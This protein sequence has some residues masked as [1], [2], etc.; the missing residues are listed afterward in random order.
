MDDKSMGSIPETGSLPA[1]GRLAVSYVPTQKPNS[2]QYSAADALK[3]GTLFPGLNLPFRNHI[4]NRAI[5][6]SPLGEIMIMSFA[7]AELGLYLDTH[8]EDKEALL[9]HNNYVR[10]LR[11][12]VEVYER[13][14]GPLTQQAVMEGKF[15]WIQDPWP[16]EANK[17]G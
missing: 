6:E 2:P 17:E 3:N 9:L 14:I 5:A 13:E 4:P 16:W 10:L 15:T 11:N 1:Q 7:V 8:P 12:A